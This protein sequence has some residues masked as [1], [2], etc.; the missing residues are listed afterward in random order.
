MCCFLCCL[1]L[2]GLVLPCPLLVSL[3]LLLL[4]FLGLCFLRSLCL[5]HWLLLGRLVGSGTPTFLLQ[6]IDLSGHGH[7][8]F[9]IFCG[10]GPGIF[11]I[12]QSGFILVFCPY[13][14][15]L[16]HEHRSSIVTLTLEVLDVDDKFF[17]WGSLLCRP[18]RDSREGQPLLVLTHEGDPSAFVPND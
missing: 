13:H 18:S 3:L 10:L 9:L 16:R 2:W 15:V 1:S 4:H 6:G 11:F 5:A 8:L 7:N 17:I 14:G 12:Q